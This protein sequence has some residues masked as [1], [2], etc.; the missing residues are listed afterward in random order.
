[1]RW[2]TLVVTG[3]SM[4]MNSVME[5]KANKVLEVLM[6]SA[7]STEILA[8]K[9]L[10][11]AALTG[12]VLLAWGAMGVAGFA[13]LIP[14][15]GA[16]VASV[17]MTD[18]L[19]IYLFAYLAGGYLM[20]AVIFA[21]IG[22]FCETP[23]EAQTL[24]GPIMMILIVPLLVMQLAMRSPDAMVVK[25]LSWIPLFTPFLMSAR[26]PSGPPLIEIIGTIAAM[27]LTV[28]IVTWL[29]GRAFR[30]GALSGIKLDWKS[31]GRVLKRDA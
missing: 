8:G 15:I 6:S 25:V 12:T 9:V 2:W 13:A 23:R 16:D 28:V 22:A 19:L 18:G 31:L 11:V 24:I 3:A 27:A 21:A 10:G 26:A 20:Y 5:E 7:S 29:A 17:L 1:M 14:E 4:L 30:A